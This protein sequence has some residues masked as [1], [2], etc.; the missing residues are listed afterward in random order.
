MNR[1]TTDDLKVSIGTAQQTSVDGEQVALRL[2]AQDLVCAI[3]RANML[4]RGVCY[5]LIRII[6]K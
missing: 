5:I 3:E 6:G 1:N 2:F 4:A